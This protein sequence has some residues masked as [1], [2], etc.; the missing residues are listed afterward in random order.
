MKDVPM[1]IELTR[2]NLIDKQKIRKEV[3]NVNDLIRFGRFYL[4]LEIICPTD[5]SVTKENQVF[6]KAKSE[7][8]KELKRREVLVNKELCV[9]AA[10]VD[11]LRERDANGD[12]KAHS[13]AKKLVDTENKERNRDIGDIQVSIRKIVSKIVKGKTGFSNKQVRSVAASDFKK[14]V[15]VRGAF[16]NETATSDPKVEKLAGAIF[17]ELDKSV[18]V[19]KEVDT[20]RNAFYLSIKDYREDLISYLEKSRNAA[21]PLDSTFKR[22]LFRI[23]KPAASNADRCRDDLQ[24]HVDDYVSAIDK[25]EKA[26]KNLAKKAQ[27]AKKDGVPI[28][29]NKLR[30]IDK[31]KK[32]ALGHLTDIKNKLTGYKEI[33]VST[34]AY[35][36]SPLDN[37]ASVKDNGKWDT[38]NKTLKALKKVEDDA[39]NLKEVF[40]NGLIKTIK[41]S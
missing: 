4:N 29:K 7:A 26:V 10:Q 15:L 38:A 37:K 35:F 17:K 23:Y 8:E 41:E 16:L 3:S 24:K 13:E 25:T 28:Y 39:K 32:T 22:E 2:P 1:T 11:K 19:A 9:M 14:M 33:T 34:R 18:R 12:Q 36:K 27:T 40:D 30:A 6:T 21:R 5:G 31:E 20:L